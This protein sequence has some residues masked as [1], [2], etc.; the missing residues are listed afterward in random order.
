MGRDEMHLF[1]NLNQFQ[2]QQ[3]SICMIQ[4]PFTDYPEYLSVSAS[5]YRPFHNMTIFQLG[6]YRDDANAPRPL[7][8][9]VTAMLYKSA[10]LYKTAGTTTV[11]VENENMTKNR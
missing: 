9:L 3:T 2:D 6:V 4:A 11:D 1:G 8:R 5:M 7:R 10:C